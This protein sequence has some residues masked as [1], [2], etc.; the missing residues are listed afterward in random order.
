MYCVHTIWI[1]MTIVVKHEMSS[2]L[3]L[4]FTITKFKLGVTLDKVIKTSNT[5]SQKQQKIN[6]LGIVLIS[7]LH[8]FCV[9]IL[10][11]HNFLLLNTQVQGHY[12]LHPKAIKRYLWLTATQV[13]FVSPVTQ[14]PWGT[15]K[16]MCRIHQL[17][18]MIPRIVCHF[19][20]GWCRP[21]EVPT[22]STKR[23]FSVIGYCCDAMWMLQLYKL[24][25]IKLHFFMNVNWDGDI[26]REL[27]LTENCFRST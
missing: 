1:I 8:H 10:L 2:H 18:V 15:Y 5:S 23:L 22:Q 25:H 14:T 4:I 9:I 17:K 19:L 3:S 7:K 6:F 16:S 24:I 27:A 12:L 21:I 13:A 26:V 11:I 20:K